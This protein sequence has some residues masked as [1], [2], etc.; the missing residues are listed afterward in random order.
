MAM[1]E[2]SD[3]PIHHPIQ[4]RFSSTN[5]ME[6]NKRKLES[7]TGVLIKKQKTDIEEA[8]TSSLPAPIITLEGHKSEVY[9]VR[10]HPS[11]S[12]LATCSFDKSICNSIFPY[13]L[14]LWNG[15]NYINYASLKEHKNAVLEIDFSVDG[16]YLLSCSADKSVILT[17]VETG[18][19]VR[20]YRAHSSIANS[21]SSSKSA[22]STLFLS[23]S[24]D[25]SCKL[26]DS[27]SK[28][29]N[30]VFKSNAPV[31]SVSFGKSDTVV[32]SA[33]VDNVITIWDTRKAEKSVDVLSGHKDSITGIKLSPT[34]EFLL[35]NSMDNTLKIWDVRPFAME[36]QIASFGGHSHGVD[37]NLLRCSW[38]SDGNMV[39]SG[40]SDGLVNIFNV[41][42]KKLEYRLPGHKATVN[43]VIFHPRE[44][45]VVSC[46]SDKVVFLGELKE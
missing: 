8:R 31:L 35:S 30:S 45:I 42:K 24:N 4:I 12:I 37:R 3:W 2:F 21:V 19:S 13:V 41:D 18:K 28:T 33:G 22:S 16:D 29:S 32:Y 40:S 15:V 10:Y 5:D 6:S 39:S 20:K 34:G 36:K 23:G 44:P 43:D 27:R 25:R 38:S 26:W 11:G 14:V 9:S 1:Q 7:E 17:D 46:G